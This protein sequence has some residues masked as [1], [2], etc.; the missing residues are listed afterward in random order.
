ML[1]GRL[2][3]ELGTGDSFRV[4]RESRFDD[5]T[6]PIVFVL[7][8]VNPERSRAQARVRIRFSE[9]QARVLVGMLQKVLPKGEVFSEDEEACI[10]SLA[11]RVTE[12][13]KVSMDTVREL[14]AAEIEQAVQ[15]G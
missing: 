12:D 5:D 7:A 13:E 14:I 2:E 6:H 11:W 9:E 15:G 1:D 4:N 3:G 10:R 8:H